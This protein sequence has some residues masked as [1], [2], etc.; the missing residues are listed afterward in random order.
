MHRSSNCRAAAKLEDGRWSDVYNMV[1]AVSETLSEDALV[2][3]R[4]YTAI[5]QSLNIQSFIPDVK[6]VRGT[7]II[8]TNNIEQLNVN[9]DCSNISSALELF[10]I[11]RGDSSTI[12]CDVGHVFSVSSDAVKAARLAR[13]QQQ[14]ADKAVRAAAAGSKEQPSRDSSSNTGLQSQTPTICAGNVNQSVTNNDIV[15]S[16]IPV[17]SNPSDTS[18]IVCDKDVM[19]NADEM[20]MT[21]HDEMIK[22]QQNDVSLSQYF[23]MAQSH[24]SE[25]FVRE[26]DKLLYRKTVLHGF[27][28]FQ[29]VLPVSKRLQVMK[30]AHDMEMGGGHFAYK[31]T[32]QRIATTFWWPETMKKDVMAYTKS[33]NECQL[34]QRVSGTFTIILG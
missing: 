30:M 29:L 1:C 23:K 21:L 27:S 33:C 31:K 18:H 14:R 22:A 3:P 17:I 15:L 10:V 19:L 9:A 25:F 34:R 16:N 2:T 11:N 20:N 13:K 32:L 12:D 26:S 8:A 6:V 24:K 4:D 28:V 7:N 5:V